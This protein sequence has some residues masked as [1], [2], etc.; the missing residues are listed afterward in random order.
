MVLHPATPCLRRVGVKVHKRITCFKSCSVSEPISLASFRVE[1][2]A[3]DQSRPQISQWVFQRLM[4]TLL[5]LYVMDQTVFYELTFF[6]HSSS[7]KL[8]IPLKSELAVELLEKG[9]VR[10]WLQAE[11]ISANGKVEYVFNDN[12]LSQGEVSEQTA[13]EPSVNCIHNISM[14]SVWDVFSL[15]CRNTRWTLTR[16][17][18]WLRWSWSVWPRLMRAPSPSRWRMGRPPTSPAWYW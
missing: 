12:V 18:V 1:E 3:G 2:A 16:T 13:N 6:L 7:S 11:K 4:S 10:F 15:I 8:V 17:P 5:L 14:K 9:R